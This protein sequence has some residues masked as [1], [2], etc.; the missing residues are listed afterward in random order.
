M[1]RTI[2]LRTF[3]A[4]SVA[5]AAAA[6]HRNQ[7]TPGNVLPSTPAPV[8]QPSSVPAVVPDSG[9]VKP[10]VDDGD[11]V[12]TVVTPDF[13]GTPHEKDDVDHLAVGSQLVDSGKLDLGIA[14]LEKAVFDNPDDFDVRKATGEAYLQKGD[15][16]DAI[17]H[18]RAAL[19]QQEDVD[20]RMEL[21]QAYF[22]LRDYD[23]A[24]KS[25][26]KT[27]SLDK[28]RPEPYELLSRVYANREMWKESIDASEEAIARGS[29]SAT[30]YNGLGYAELMLGRY[31]DAVRELGRAVAGNEGVTPAMWNNLGIAFQKT[32]KVAEAAES[33]RCALQENPTYVKAKVNLDH[34]TQ[35]AKAQGIA[36]GP[37]K[38]ELDKDDLIGKTQP[39]PT[40][41]GTG[42]KQVSPTPE[43]TPSWQTW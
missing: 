27:A 19:D 35:L 15:L 30:T 28:T 6:C 29:D 37:E 9:S 16:E 1:N 32:G 3:F 26:V 5:F 34:V 14:E 22:D 25:I 21:S 13:G 23:A 11:E 39:Q 4:L 12:S 42:E 10:E 20:V 18:L 2:L 33:F 38:A 41:D 7:P 17:G 36:I 43:P 40:G 31:D 24:T 8:V